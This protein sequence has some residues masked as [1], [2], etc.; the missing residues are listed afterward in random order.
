LI[1]RSS[2]PENRIQE[3]QAEVDELRLYLEMAV[4]NP[5]GVDDTLPDEKTPKKT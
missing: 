3:L 1:Q 4:G 2:N 5:P